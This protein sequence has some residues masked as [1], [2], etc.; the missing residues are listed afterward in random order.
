[1]K[2]QL[3]DLEKGALLQQTSGDSRNYEQSGLKVLRRLN[4]SPIDL[5]WAHVVRTHEKLD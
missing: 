1:M 2:P 4:A 3:G 5:H